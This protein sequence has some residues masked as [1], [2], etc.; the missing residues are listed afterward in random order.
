M[1]KIIMS[2]L[3]ICALAVTSMAQKNK[4]PIMIPSL[5]VDNETGLYS[6]VKVVEVPNTSKDELYNRAFA[7]ANLYYKNPGDVIREKDPAN[8]KMVIK[9]R[10]KIFNEP[11]KKGVTTA[12]GDVMYTLN[13]GFKEGKFRYEVTKINWQ[14]L[15]YYPI[16]RW[17]DTT[18][19][20]FRPEYAYY[21][22]LTDEKI[23]EVTKDLEKKVT[24]PP[25]VKKE[26][27]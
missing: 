1:K 19:T 11:D 7:W 5:P 3:C 18:V 16:E 25:K 2:C 21:L 4:E 10:F 17:K 15:S 27:W 23:N 8:G 24:A 20:S 12:A 9:A 26:D 6:Y 13:L 22:K 14:Q